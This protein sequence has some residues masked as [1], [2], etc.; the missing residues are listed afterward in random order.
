MDRGELAEYIISN[1]PKSY[2]DLE[3]EGVDGKHTEFKKILP[4]S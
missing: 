1:A 3:F 4:G 2:E